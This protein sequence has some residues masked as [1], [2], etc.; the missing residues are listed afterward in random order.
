MVV[1]ER[2]I[3]L[4]SFHRVG[5]HAIKLERDQ[6]AAVREMNAR[7]AD[8]TIAFEEVD[9]LCGSDEFDLLATTDRYGIDQKTVIC[10]RCGLVQSNPR[11]TESSYRAFYESEEYRRVYDGD[12]FLDRYEAIY[13]DGRGELVFERVTDRRP[14]SEISSLLEFGAGGG[15]NL[16]PFMDAGVAATGYDYSAALVAGGREKGIDLHQGGIDEVT[17]TYD[18]IVANHVVEHLLDVPAVL[19]KLSQH[20]APDGL[21]WIE[22]PNIESFYMGQ[23]QNAHTYYF[24][25]KTLEFAASLGG[26]RMT[27]LRP[28][29]VIS[30]TFEPD[31]GLEPLA[32]DFLAGHYDEMAELLARFERR[33]RRRAPL[34]P[35][36]R[37]LDATGL[38]DPLRR[39]T[40]RVRAT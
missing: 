17:G 34:Q 8:G 19:R 16:V 31:D 5:H 32:P 20:L 28:G 18:V 11:M 22:V 23:L 21:I 3:G 25:A 7:I 40:R 1:R 14:A 33:S 6:I 12:D 13:H 26:L 4:P 2:L 24:T 35:V 27:H 30:G 15:W 10:R 9:C 37:A 39:A 36:I 38:G 29:V